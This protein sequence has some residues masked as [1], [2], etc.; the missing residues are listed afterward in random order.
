MCLAGWLPL[1]VRNSPVPDSLCPLFLRWTWVGLSKFS[2]EPT[3][4]PL[5]VF[6][7]S[8]G[9]QV[10]CCI[11]VKHLGRAEL[12]TGDSPSQSPPIKRPC[13]DVQVS[14]VLLCFPLSSDCLPLPAQ[15]VLAVLLC[16]LIITLRQSGSNPRN[17]SSG[18]AG[19]ELK[20]FDFECH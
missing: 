10:R 3:S 6:P 2:F 7:S 12:G 9:F 11:V 1:W 15:E 17:A 16:F 8:R 5:Q 18:R 4:L 13:P 20:D 19:R 14:L